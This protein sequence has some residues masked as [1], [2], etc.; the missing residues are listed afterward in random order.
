M[1]EIEKWS[2]VIPKVIDGNEKAVGEVDRMAQND[3]YLS[4][5]RLTVQENEQ[6]Q[7]NQRNK[8]ES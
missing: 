5:G 4:T 3:E 7:D 2:H 6:R 8:D 1:V